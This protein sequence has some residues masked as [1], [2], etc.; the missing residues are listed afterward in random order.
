M[1]HMRE[2]SRRYARYRV[3]S[4]LCGPSRGPQAP[5]SQGPWTRGV[6]VSRPLAPGLLAPG[7]LARG[8]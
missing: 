1:R 3:V 4:M 2:I 5:A 8:L 7:P 6:W